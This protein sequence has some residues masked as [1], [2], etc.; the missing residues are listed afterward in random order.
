MNQ[1]QSSPSSETIRGYQNYRAFGVTLIVLISLGLSKG[2]S[3]NTV[4][5]K[6][7]KIGYLLETP[8][9]FDQ[10]FTS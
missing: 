8:I 2:K 9:F 5:I 7:C 10:F 6:Y 4:Q 1:T 3:I